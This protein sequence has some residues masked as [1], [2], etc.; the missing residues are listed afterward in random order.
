MLLTVPRRLRMKISGSMRMSGV[1]L[2]GLAALAVVAAGCGSGAGA[3]TGPTSGSTS[4]SPAVTT[5]HVVMKVLEFNPTTVDARVG[6]KLTWTNEDRSPH[7]VTYV[8]GP[9]FRSSPRMLNPGAKFTIK[10]TQPGTIHYLCTLHPW[11]KAT[12]VVSP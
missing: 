3:V 7:N 5:T 6:Q 8:S 2:P 9:R 11:M 1:S 10:L 12:I 4:T